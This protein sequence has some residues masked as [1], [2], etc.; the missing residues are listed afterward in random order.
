MDSRNWWFEVGPLTE[1][2]AEELAKQLVRQAPGALEVDVIDERDWFCRAMSPEAVRDIAVVL[3][4][5][6]DALDHST[7][8]WLTTLGVLSDMETWLQDEHRRD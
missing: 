2:A 1:V 7:D 4:G 5:A 8:A 6:L 3:R